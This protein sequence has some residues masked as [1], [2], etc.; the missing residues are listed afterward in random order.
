MRAYSVRFAAALFA[1][2]TCFVTNS[3]ALPVKHQEQ[4]VTMGAS[5]MILYDTARYPKSQLDRLVGPWHTS[6]RYPDG[7]VVEGKE[8]FV[9]VAG[10]QFLVHSWITTMP[11]GPNDGIEII[12]SGD[13]VSP[14]M[15]YDNG[16]NT[17]PSTLVI[18]R[19]EV[20][21]GGQGCVIKRASSR[22]TALKVSMKPR[23]IRLLNGSI[24]LMPRW[25][26]LNSNHILR[27]LV[28]S[29]EG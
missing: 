28:Q 21:F 7:G 16:G 25:P 5:E 19:D 3:P 15:I 11:E 22:T 14:G 8:N 23:L 2:Y 6:G 10:G 1:G 17:N 12:R 13:H 20:I 9:W 18:D 27:R 24:G 26:R 4:S 29:T